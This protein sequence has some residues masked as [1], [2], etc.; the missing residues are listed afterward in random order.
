MNPLL[1]AGFFALVAPDATLAKN[2]IAH[3]IA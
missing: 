3:T 1:S 2:A